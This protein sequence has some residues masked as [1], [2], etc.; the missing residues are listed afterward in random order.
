MEESWE[1]KMRLINKDKI[2]NEL[3][4]EIDFLRTQNYD[5]YCELGDRI[6]YIIN[7]QSCIVVN[8]EDKR[9]MDYLE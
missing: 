1:L 9:N 4:D 7:Q 2:Y 5:L 6:Q 3:I 8:Y